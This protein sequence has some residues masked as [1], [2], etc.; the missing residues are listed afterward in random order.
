MEDGLKL[1][2]IPC[3][4]CGVPLIYLPMNATYIKENNIYCSDCL[5]EA[6]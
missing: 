1:I 3:D 5:E 2:N 4:N 6:K